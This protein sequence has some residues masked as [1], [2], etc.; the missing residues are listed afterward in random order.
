L[1]KFTFF[2][3]AAFAALGLSMPAYASPITYDLTLE[4]TSGD[5]SP[6]GTGYFTING[7]IA[8]SGV[9]EF[10][11]SLGN[12]TAFNFTIDG[13]SFSLTNDPTGAVVFD[14]GSLLSINYAGSDAAGVTLGTGLLTF[15]YINSV[16]SH[17]SFGLIEFAVAAVPEPASLAIFGTALA[18]LGFLRR[19][20]RKAA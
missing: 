13:N 1:Q 8:S 17:N 4:Q 14:N 6:N 18:G 5:V 20:K 9:D 16:D 3:F 7:P 12:L 10:T 2:A 19:R 11:E 15:N